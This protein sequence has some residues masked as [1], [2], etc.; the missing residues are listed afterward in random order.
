[1]LLQEQQ[2][3]INGSK[4]LLSEELKNDAIMAYLFNIYKN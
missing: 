4:P 2:E 3:S 1:M